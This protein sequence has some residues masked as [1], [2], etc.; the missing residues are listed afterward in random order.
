MNWITI[1]GIVTIGIGTLLTYYGTS[2]SSTKDKAEITSKIDDFKQ[3][4]DKINIESLSDSEKVQAVDKIKNEFQ[5]WA[6]NFI[7]DKDEKKVLL[8]KNDVS[9]REKK[10]LLN[11][12][13][14]GYYVKTF[15]ALTQMVDAY[16][17]ASGKTNIKQ[18][19]VK[20]LPNNIYD[21]NKTNFRVQL[22]FSE[23][24]FWFIWLKVYDPI[25]S[26]ELPIINIQVTNKPND[27][28]INM[29]NLSFLIDIKTK[30]IAI[31]NI[32]DPFNKANFKKSYPLNENINQ[33]IDLI[34]QAFEYQ[35]L[36]TE[37]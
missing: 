29:S 2:L 35:I 6:D 28:F 5:S 15:E 26:D 30:T 17:K 21:A 22:Q 31:L 12:K 23:K 37:S 3:N 18:I 32:D 24:T 13:W 20:N 36:I 27:D 25:S 11:N 9:L 7:K 34:K 19:E 10:I 4:L 33:M 8:D 16:N 1:L 14:R